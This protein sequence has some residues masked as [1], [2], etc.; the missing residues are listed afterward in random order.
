MEK[1]MLDLDPILNLVLFHQVSRE[2]SISGEEVWGIILGY[3]NND[4]N[5][6]LPTFTRGSK[7]RGPSHFHEPVV[8]TPSFKPKNP[9][10]TPQPLPR[11]VKAF[12]S[13]EMARVEEANL[14]QC[15]LA[16][17]LPSMSLTMS[18]GPHQEP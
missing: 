13:G 16:T 10:E 3:G 17:A 8:R 6:G 15:S 14:G 7:S 5:G 2:R 11:F 1:L 9:K 12:M 4:L 18:R